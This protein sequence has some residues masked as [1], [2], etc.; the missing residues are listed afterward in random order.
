MRVCVWLGDVVR[1]I[2]FLALDYDKIFRG[3]VRRGEFGCGLLSVCTFDFFPAAFSRGFRFSVFRWVIEVD[4]PL[5]DTFILCGTVP[6]GQRSHQLL[7]CSIRNRIFFVHLF[8]NKKQSWDRICWFIARLSS[9]I[10]G[11]LQ[12]DYIILWQAVIGLTF[13]IIQ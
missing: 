9:F 4:L 2:G 3:Q 12:K 1:S 6:S 11:V 7:L 5:L 8:A 13:N 10:C